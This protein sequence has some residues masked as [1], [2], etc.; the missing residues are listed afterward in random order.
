MIIHTN[1]IQERN[2]VSSVYDSY[3]YNV[4]LFNESVQS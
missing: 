2:D 3:N 4:N 1:N